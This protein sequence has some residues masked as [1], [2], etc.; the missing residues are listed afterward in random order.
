[1]EW[2]WSRYNCESLASFVT[3]RAV[4]FLKLPENRLDLTQSQG[5]YQLIKAIYKALVE[6]QIQYAHE[7]YNPSAA[8]QRIRTP[9]E[10]LNAPGEGTCLDLAAMFCGLCLGNDLLPLLIVVNG[11]ALAAVSLN[12]S[13][14]QWDEDAKERGIFYDSPLKDVEELKRL[15][16]N[17]AY[18]AIECTGFAH[19]KSLPESSPEGLGR[20][21]EGI[22]PFERA[23]IA[24][25]E[26]LDHP[27]RPFKFALDIA[28]AHYS[29]DI[30]P[31]DFPTQKDSRNVS[32]SVDNR[33]GGVYF[34]SRTV[35]NGDVVGGNQT[36]N[37]K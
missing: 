18:L 23:I 16:D 19:S 2:Q 31:V 9:A 13:R 14:C 12:Y 8:S 17:E 22:L 30:K 20:T 3:D 29:W 10:I 11:H 26:Q 24:G 37:I 15:I 34:E 4:E 1:M 21:K 5:R 7:K 35:I 32:I 25:R 36:K 6:K 33:S 27:D 28:T